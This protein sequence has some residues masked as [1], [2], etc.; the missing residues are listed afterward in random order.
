SFFRRHSRRFGAQEIRCP[1]RDGR[2]LDYGYFDERELAVIGF[3]SH[4]NFLIGFNWES[5]REVYHQA[6]HLPR[7]DLLQANLGVWSIH[8][9]IRQHQSVGPLVEDLYRG[10][11]PS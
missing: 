1:T 3:H 5:R 2:L 10:T 8:P 11:K 9:R 6:K 4:L 7:L